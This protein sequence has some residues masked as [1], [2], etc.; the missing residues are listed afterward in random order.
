MSVIINSFNIGPVRA[1][2]GAHGRVVWFVA[3]IS[4]KCLPL[5]G[6]CFEC[7]YDTAH[8]CCDIGYAKGT[9]EQIAL[10]SQRPYNQI[11]GVAATVYILTQ[12]KMIVLCT[13][14]CCRL[15]IFYISSKQ[16]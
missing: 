14:G 5:A 3:G 15:H 1:I 9:T 16:K 10:M 4:F 2:P 6:H 12:M 13:E 7:M 11:A 8:T